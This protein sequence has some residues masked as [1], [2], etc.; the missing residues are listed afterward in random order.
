DWACVSPSLMS[1]PPSIIVAAMSVTTAALAYQI[2]GPTTGSRSSHAPTAL[3]RAGE[4]SLSRAI[5]AATAATTSGGITQT[6]PP[7]A[8][9][10][11]AVA[12]CSS[13]PIVEIVSANLG[14]TYV[15][16]NQTAPI[17]VSSSS[18]G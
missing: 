15:A 2:S 4:S 12:Q 7:A 8:A 10:V 1:P 11:N 3:R 14:M 13:P 9:S 17:A 18:A 16:R 5:T 6:S